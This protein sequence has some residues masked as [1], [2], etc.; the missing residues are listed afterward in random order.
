M[1]LYPEF[2]KHRSACKL[3]PCRAV[4]GPGGFF[5]FGRFLLMA[6]HARL[7]S[8]RCRARHNAGL[9]NCSHRML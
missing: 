5:A 8:K 4:A 6:L 7:S 9:R 2:Q 1:Q 3:A